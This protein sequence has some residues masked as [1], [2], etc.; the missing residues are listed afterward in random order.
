MPG[1]GVVRFL[2]GQQH[3]DKT[4]KLLK[5]CSEKISKKNFVC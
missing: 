4:F 5:A 3:R 1:E 2:P